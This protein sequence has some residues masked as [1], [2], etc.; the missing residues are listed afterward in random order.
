MLYTGLNGK[1]LSE[2]TN[3]LYSASYSTDNDTS[4]GVPYLR[5]FLGEDQHD[6]IFSPNTQPNPETSED[7][8]HTWNVTE[9]TVR[10]DDDAGNNPDPPGQT[11]WRLTATR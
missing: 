8:S 2:I 1:K 11:W 4:V 10:Y 7:E 9:G 3:L 6:V 5:V